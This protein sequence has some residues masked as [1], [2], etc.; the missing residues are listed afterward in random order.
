M[1]RSA[2]DGMDMKAGQNVPPA[3]GKVS[4]LVVDDESS[5]RDLCQDIAEG[6]GLAVYQAG[7]AA[8]A[9]RQ[10]E[11][12][13]I[14]MVLLDERLP[15]TTGV[16]LLR[17]IKRQ[18]PDVEVTMMSGLAPAGPTLAA[19]ERGAKD[20]LGKPF[21]LVE[22]RSALQRMMPRKPSALAKLPLEPLEQ[23]KPATFTGM[24]ARSRAMLDVYST[25]AKVAAV[26]GPVLIRGERGTGKK[27]AAQAIHF[28]GPW[29][30]RPFVEIDC[31]ADGTKLE[32]QLFPQ[33]KSTA[34]RFSRTKE[35]GPPPAI[36]AT[37][38]LDEI[39][40]VPLKFQHRI[41]EAIQANEVYMT[42]RSKNAPAEV[43]ILAA[44]SQDLTV[45]VS[46]GRFLRELLA[47]LSAVT[48]DLPPLR[49]RREDIQL[50]VE[51]FLRG[52]S[53]STGVER[54]LSR[55]AMKLL[56][57]YDWPGNVRELEKSLEHALAAGKDTV[58]SAQMLPEY[59]RSF[60]SK[61]RSTRSRNGI[62]PLAEVE[63]LA[64]LGA[65]EQLKG[66]K[67]RAAKLLGIGKTTL[68]R[69]LREYGI[70]IP[71]RKSS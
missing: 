2:G 13:P 1:R 38:F 40:R 69:K 52:L 5:I 51:H 70:V 46:Q 42:A 43:R 68:F 7:D 48:L 37:V 59:I 16:D 35:E 14:D 41:L 27:M 9:L 57:A 24:V 33:N 8:A 31:G 15:G 60:K 17:R 61:E 11:T 58:V 10:M 12:H 22:L 50:L 63:R 39:A 45:A 30:E 26:R 66:D 56:L 49:E 21:T 28:S 64:I 4:L 65:V 20:F 25:I 55:D 32:E 36:G 29:R 54:L 67:L 44:T 53:R 23:R 3:T 47:R 18:R 34:T 19:L 62:M 71:D 6:M